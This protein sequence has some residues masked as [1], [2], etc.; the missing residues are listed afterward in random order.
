MKHRP[1][2]SQAQRQAAADRLPEGAN[3]AR[4][5]H[6]RYGNA[7][8][9]PALLQ[10]PNYANSPLPGNVVSDW[11]AI[12]QNALQPMPMPG[13]P[14]PMGNISMA[15]AFVYLTYTQSAV[16]NA[17]LRWKAATSRTRLCHIRMFIII[18]SDV[19]GGH[20]KSLISP[21]PSPTPL[22]RAR[23]RLPRRLSAFWSTI[24][25]RIPPFALR[26]EDTLSPSPMDPPRQPAS[27]SA[28]RLPRISS[29][30]APATACSHRHLHRTR[31]RS[32]RVGARQDARRHH[33]PPSRSLD[34]RLKPF[35]TIAGAIPPGA[36]PAPDDPAYVADL[37]EVKDFGSAM[38]ALRTPAQTEM[39][40]FW[41]TN[42][43]IQTN[44]AYRQ[45]AASRGLNLLDTARLM[46][47][48][49]M[50]AT[51]SLIATFDTKYTY[52]FWRPITAIQRPIRTA[53]FD[54]S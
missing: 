14:M 41:T 43:V 13:M 32:G 44:A 50:V 37:N 19:S 12:A 1:R 17:L 8:C 4:P 24:S 52:N 23:R 36:S 22:P 7:G 33:H 5:S 49:N 31:A 21:K 38:S 30:C 34:G 29:P 46:A 27:P 16:Y 42:M 45:I 53:I 26:N 40:L 28:R 15:T 35:F 47:M 51:D 54:R 3:P 9:S 48:G 11:N 18:A 20:A 2:V 25:P 10:H 6:R 39:A